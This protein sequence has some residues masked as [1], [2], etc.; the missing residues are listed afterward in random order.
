MFLKIIC[1]QHFRLVLE[2][3][4]LGSVSCYRR[5]KN[6]ICTMDT[7]I[8]GLRPTHRWKISI[9]ASTVHDGGSFCDP[10]VGNSIFVSTIFLL[11]F[12]YCGGGTGTACICVAF[13]RKPSN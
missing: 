4:V 8:G 5:R 3:F 1:P 13:V 6:R 7:H 11:V 10:P 12:F 9:F 2:I